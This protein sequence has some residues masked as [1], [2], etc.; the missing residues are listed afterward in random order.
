MAGSRSG[1]HMPTCCA[2]VRALL[3][4]S[5]PSFPTDSQVVPGPRLSVIIAT[6]GPARLPGAVPLSSRAPRSR[7]GTNNSNASVA[8]SWNVGELVN[9]VREFTGLA[10]NPGL[11]R[12]QTRGTCEKWVVTSRG[13]SF[14]CAFLFFLDCPRCLNTVRCV[15]ER[16]SF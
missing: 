4:S 10:G 7:K 11:W 6:L 3:V 13:A 16:V 14:L 2:R 9:N 12:A 5:S 1:G 8:A 15:E